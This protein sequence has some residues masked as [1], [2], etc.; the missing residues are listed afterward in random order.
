MA[1]AVGCKDP[2]RKPSVVAKAGESGGG[3]AQLP[4]ASSVPEVAP[5]LAEEAFKAA[6]PSSLCSPQKPGGCQL[7]GVRG[8]GANDTD[9]SIVR[10]DEVVSLMGWGADAAAGTV[11]PVIVIEIAGPT[12]KFYASATRSMKR[13]DVAVALNAPGLANAGFEMLASF[14]NVDPGDYL[15]NIFQVNAAGEALACETHRKLRVE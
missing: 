13:P 15:V 5:V 8:I 10:R 6:V 11:P 14:R 9:A 12:K 1:M 2:V 4:P 7:D 3:A